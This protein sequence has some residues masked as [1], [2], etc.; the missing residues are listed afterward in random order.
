MGIPGFYKFIS[1]SPAL[2]NHLRNGLR[3]KLNISNFTK[4]TILVDGTEVLFHVTKTNKVANW[5]DIIAHMFKYICGIYTQLIQDNGSHDINAKIFVAF[6][7]VYPKTR[8]FT[9]RERAYIEVVHPSREFPEWFKPYEISA[10][11]KTYENAIAQLQRM[12]WPC[13]TTIS[14]PHLPGS[15]LYKLE[16]HVLLKSNQER[17][18][19]YVGTGADIFVSS[20][21]QASKHPNQIPVFLVAGRFKMKNVIDVCALAKSIAQLYDSDVNESNVN[22]IACYTVQD[23]VTVATII[24][25]TNILPRAGRLDVYTGGID[26]GMDVY[27]QCRNELKL[28]GQIEND[29]NNSFKPY[30]HGRF[31]HLDGSPNYKNI[32]FWMLK[33]SA[34]QDNSLSSPA[35]LNDNYDEEKNVINYCQTLDWV[36]RSVNGRVSSWSWEPQKMFKYAPNFDTVGKIICTTLKNHTSHIRNDKPQNVYTQLSVVLPPEIHGQYLPPYLLSQVANVIKNQSME[37]PKSVK[38]M[39]IGRLYSRK[40][41]APHKKYVPGLQRHPLLPVTNNLAYNW[42][43]SV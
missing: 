18:L 20:L 40:T 4:A 41:S 19:I 1:A 43:K 13:D 11:M 7:G 39:E 14:L 29:I 37:Y 27:I 32:A 34:M 22:N 10:G 12:E 8:L 28:L 5:D 3:R 31:Y 30:L 25:G 23:F 36:L 6:S 2:H 42:R 35:G 33:V 24:G 16:Q 38:T 17:A 15:S 21:R 9:R 26:K